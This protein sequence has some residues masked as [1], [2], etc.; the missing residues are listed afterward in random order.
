M[1]DNVRYVYGASTI[2]FLCTPAWILPVFA[3]SNRVD[4]ARVGKSAGAASPVAGCAR[5]TNLRSGRLRE[6]T[7][8]QSPIASGGTSADILLHGRE[9]RECPGAAEPITQAEAAKPRCLT[10]RRLNEESFGANYIN[11]LRYHYQ[12][13]FCSQRAPT[14]ALPRLL[15]RTSGAG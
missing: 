5:A 2:G 15:C 4:S 14:T 8:V 12:D 9:S 7:G 1:N 13:V 6:T 10:H 3:T 11:V